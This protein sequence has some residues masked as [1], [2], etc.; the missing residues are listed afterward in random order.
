MSIQ[1]VPFF[2]YGHEF[3][4]YCPISDEVNLFDSQRSNEQYYRGSCNIGNSRYGEILNLANGETK[5]RYSRFSD[6]IME[7][8]SNESFCA[9]SSLIR[10]NENSSSLI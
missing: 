4:E 8:Y 3:I 7:N 6:I 10:K 5:I 1:G 2:F 9:L